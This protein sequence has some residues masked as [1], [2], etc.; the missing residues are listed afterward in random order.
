M[1][2]T[3]FIAGAICPS[4]GSI[5]RVA[6]TPDDQKIYCTNCDF[7]EVKTP[8]KSNSKNLEKDKAKH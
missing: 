7:A 2:K 8:E 1:K 6:L 5:D 3:R 4:C